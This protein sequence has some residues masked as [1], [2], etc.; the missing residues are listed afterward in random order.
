[1]Y[2]KLEATHARILRIKPKYF[3]RSSS[4][5]LKIIRAAE[6]CVQLDMQCTYQPCAAL[7]L[8]LPSPVLLL[9]A[10]LL[11]LEV[12]LLLARCCSQPP[13]LLQCCLAPA[14]A[15][16][17]AAAGSSSQAQRPAAGAAEAGATRS[18]ATAKTAT[19]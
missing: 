5:Q 10:R 17:A 12:W 14:A 3:Q 11:L 19:H 16:G 15:T 7:P 1:M 6:H 8:A 18:A 9:S 4:W 13:V 2:S